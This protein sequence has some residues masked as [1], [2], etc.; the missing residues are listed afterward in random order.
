MLHWNLNHFSYFLYLF[1][2]SP[3]I[4][5][6]YFW[7][8]FPFYSHS[9]CAQCHFRIFCYYHRLI[10]IRIYYHKF[11][12]SYPPTQVAHSY[13]LHHSSKHLIK[14]SKLFA[15][16]VPKNCLSSLNSAKHYKIPLNQRSSQKTPFYPF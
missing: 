1:G 11:Y 4:F 15:H 5:I 12:L 3:N 10:R 8:F 7:N 14:S 2:K 6:I 9:F 16:I 13:I